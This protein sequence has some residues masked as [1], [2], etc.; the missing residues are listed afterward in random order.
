M[1]R[2]AARSPTPASFAGRGARPRSRTWFARA[3]TRRWFSLPWRSGREA[4][5]PTGL[6]LG[7][8][9][10]AEV[11]HDTRHRTMRNH[12][13]THLLHAALRERLGTHVH[14]A[15]SAVRPGQAAVR[16]H[17]RPPALARGGS[18]DRGRRQRLGQGKPPGPRDGDGAKG[19]ARAGRDGPLRREVRRLG[20]HGRDRRRLARALRRHA[21]R[22]ERRVRDLRDRPGDFERSERAP[23]R[24]P[25]RPRR[26]RL[27]PRAEPGPRRARVPSSAPRR[28]PLAAAERAAERLSELERSAAEGRAG[29]CG[30]GGREARVRRRR[31]SAASAWS[32]RRAA[33]RT[34]KALAELGSRVRDKLGDA[35]VVLGAPSDGKV[36]LVAVASP[37]AVKRGVSAAAMVREAAPLVG[38]GGGGRD[39]SAQAGGP[40]SGEAPRG[41]RS[42]PGSRFARRSAADD[43]DANPC[44]RPWRSPCGRGH[45]RSDR[46]DR[47]A[48][49]AS[50]GPTRPRSA[51]WLNRRAPRWSSWGSRSPCRAKRVRRPRAPA[52]MPRQLEELL[53]IPVVTYDERLTTRMAS[54]SS[55]AG[56][57][58]PSDAL[59]AAHLL[60]SFLQH[61]AGPA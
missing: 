44:P 3:M 43:P 57:G 48:R 11:D 14:Q 9:V 23:D 19:G 42:R 20:A 13:A 29:C 56:A 36:A 6:V 33:W 37:A 2:A 35:V 38:G 51:R 31:T 46:D 1:P 58:A 32:W 10:E 41:T 5:E 45:L 4:E 8:R 30:R 40:R 52:H 50:S 55:R 53:D 39:E 61:R 26:D 28:I 34:A 54:S 18:R 15:G 21:R 27:V 49:R 24:G 16:L 22:L 60:E 25:D 7:A 12:T 59:A 47:G 17:A